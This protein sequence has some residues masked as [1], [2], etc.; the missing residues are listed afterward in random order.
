MKTN[1]WPRHPEI[2]P[3]LK[4]SSVA[5]TYLQQIADA[6]LPLC[7]AFG[8]CLRDVLPKDIDPSS[9]WQASSF[10]WRLNR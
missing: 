1:N 7:A 3:T 4:S 5:L 10:T 2:N 6:G 9:R 8:G